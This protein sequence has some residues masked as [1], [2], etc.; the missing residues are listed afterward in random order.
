MKIPL[1]LI[2]GSPPLEKASQVWL[3]FKRHHHST[4]TGY[5]NLKNVSPS[6]S[7]TG[8]VLFFFAVSRI[9][10]KEGT[11]SNAFAVKTGLLFAASSVPSGAFLLRSSATIRS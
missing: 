2:N 3:D 4:Q 6:A 11:N 7:H 8:V 5:Q 1:A 10:F 9:V